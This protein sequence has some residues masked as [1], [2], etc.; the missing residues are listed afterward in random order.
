MGLFDQVLS[1]AEDLSQ[2]QG[3]GN[4]TIL[5][6]ITQIINDPKIGGISGL[7]QAFENG[8]LSDIVKSWV[9]TGQNLPISADQIQAVLGNEQIQSIAGKLGINAEE[10]PGKLAE[11]LPQVIDKLTPNG[12]VP[13]G[14]SLLTEGI[15]LLKG[16]LF[17]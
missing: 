8:G 14:E 3:G 2:N 15:D 7:V 16:K 12:T 13:S 11:Y 17:S 9:S 1:A 4:N 5:G 10:I 6:A